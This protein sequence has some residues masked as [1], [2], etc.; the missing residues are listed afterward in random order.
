MSQFPKPF[1]G[2][3]SG[4]KAPTVLD[5]SDVQ[6]PVKHDFSDIFERDKFDGEFVV[7]C[8]WRNIF[9]FLLKLQ[10]HNAFYFILYHCLFYA[11]VEATDK[12]CVDVSPN[13]VFI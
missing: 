9:N 7:K 11:D 10:S 8:E 3:S 12:P 1:S 2:N 4:N 6:V 13:P 5:E